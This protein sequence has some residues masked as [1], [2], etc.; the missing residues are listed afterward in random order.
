VEHDE[1]NVLVMGSRIVGT[2]LAHDITEHYLS[3]KFNASE[4]RFVRRLNKVKAIEH[5]Y[6][7]GAGSLAS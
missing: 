2:A 5:F 7:R 1:M 4:E 3:A 6:M